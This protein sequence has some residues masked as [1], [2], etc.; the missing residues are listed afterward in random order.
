MNFVLE[1]RPHLVLI[2]DQDEVIGTASSLLVFSPFRREQAEFLLSWDV[3]KTIRHAVFISSSF[4]VLQLMKSK[5]FNAFDPIGSFEDIFYFYLFGLAGHTLF[6]TLRCYNLLEQIGLVLHLKYFILVFKI[7][8]DFHSLAWLI[9]DDY[10]FHRVLFQINECFNEIK[11]L[12][13]NVFL[14][15]DVAHLSEAQSIR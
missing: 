11:L 13:D 8:E 2:F 9:F 10:L 15:I 3:F 12:F 6:I 14:N 7:E 1:G 5:F 4:V